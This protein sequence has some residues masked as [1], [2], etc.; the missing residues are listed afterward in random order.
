MTTEAKEAAEAEG[1]DEEDT[2]VTLADLLATGKSLAELAKSKGRSRQLQNILASGDPATIGKLCDGVEPDFLELV[3]DP[4][5]NYLMQ[6]VLE[7]CDLEQFRRCFALLAGE[8]R[9]LA[10]DVHGTRAVQKG[11]EQAISREQLTLLQEAV[12]NELVAELARHATGFHV[13]MKLLD[14]LPAAWR[15]RLLEALAGT[16]EK[17]LSLGCD[18]WGCCVMK[19]CLD[20]SE[21]EVHQRLVDA[22]LSETLA[23][24]QDKYGNYVVQHLINSGHP[25]ANPQGAAVV[26]ALKG[27]VCELALQKCSS[28]VLE[29]CLKVC[30]EK[31]RNKIINEILT[32]PGGSP[33]QALHKLLFHEFGNY[34][35]QQAL[36]VSREPQY[37][38]LIEHSRQHIQEVLLSGEDGTGVDPIG[39]SR[40]HMKKV[41][42]KLVK[43]HTALAEGLD[44][45]FLMNPWPLDA[46]AAAAWI[47]AN[48]ACYEMWAGYGGDAALQSYDFPPGISPFE[49]AYPQKKTKKGGKGGQKTSKQAPADELSGAKMAGFWPH[50]Y[51]AYDEAPATEQ[52]SSQADDK[53]K[54][55]KGGNK[56]AQKS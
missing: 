25:K 43:R 9:T 19:K 16:P 21:G 45:D 14:S 54:T 17:A 37:S 33:S 35:F 10:E 47:A 1:V 42:Q 34:V 48:A 44:M 51:V 28:N 27:H 6:K 18:Q 32:Q 15:E 11:V 29:K 20:H 4:F 31:E 36:E 3:K 49:N 46:N 24:V 12:P 55:K 41:C 39:M 23:L 38:L 52:A 13:V 8:V 53:T 50:Y 2:V 7:V 22:I 5:G 30:E 26:D 40:Q 56:A